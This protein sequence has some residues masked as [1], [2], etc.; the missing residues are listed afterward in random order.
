MVVPAGLRSVLTANERMGGCPRRC[1]R[2]LMP[3]PF[4]I[5]WIVL[6]EIVT[7]SA[8]VLVFPPRRCDYTA[9]PPQ[10]VVLQADPATRCREVLLL[11]RPWTVPVAVSFDW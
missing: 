8:L 5:C 1:R 10:F 6:P 3:N 11:M 2:T 9:M 4:W 7:R